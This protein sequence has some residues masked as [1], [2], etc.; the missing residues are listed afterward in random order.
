M[1]SEEAKKSYINMPGI[2]EDS[3]EAFMDSYNQGR[4][5]A[6][7]SLKQR[8]LAMEYSAKQFPIT[9]FGSGQITTIGGIILFIDEMLPEG[10][11]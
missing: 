1:V 8:L 9:D 6:L 3:R 4:A 10:E 11:R 2:E 5:D 7:H